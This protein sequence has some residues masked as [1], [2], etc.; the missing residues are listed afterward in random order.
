MERRKFIISSCRFC[1]AAALGASFVE[2]TGCG[3][4]YQVMKTPILNNKVELPL[5]AFAQTNT[6]FVRPQGWYFDIAVQKKEDNTY[7]ALLLQCTHQENQLNVSADGFTCS[8]HGSKF[9]RNGKVRKGPAS[10]SLDSYKT[11]IYNNN[12]LIEV[13]KNP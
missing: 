3:T 2:L 12:L 9:D 6:I 4:P 7:S 1:A 5:T 8:L 10:K 11:T 13:P